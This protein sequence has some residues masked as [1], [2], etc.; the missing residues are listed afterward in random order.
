MFLKQTVIVYHI[1]NNYVKY[2]IKKLDVDVENIVIK[3]YNEGINCWTG[4]LE[5]HKYWSRCLFEIL[6]KNKVT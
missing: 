3:I 1:I 4:I 5:S 2:A 6:N